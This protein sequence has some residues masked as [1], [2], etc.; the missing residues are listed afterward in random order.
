[1]NKSI[2][3]TQEDYKRLRKKVGSQTEVAELLGLSR[4]TIQ[5][6]ESEKAR[7]TEEMAIALRE[8]ARQRGISED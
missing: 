3:M 5:R 7:I 4:P 6:R 2:K 8:I 1:M